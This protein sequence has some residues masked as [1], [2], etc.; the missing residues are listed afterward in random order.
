MED[1]VNVTAIKR[2]VET[3]G[4]GQFTNEMNL[5]IEDLRDLLEQG[6]ENDSMDRGRIDAIRTILAWPDTVIE[7]DDSSVLKN[8]TQ[9]GEDAEHKS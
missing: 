7:D 5:M 8:S 4:W 1:G 2:M 6:S 9:D 3:A